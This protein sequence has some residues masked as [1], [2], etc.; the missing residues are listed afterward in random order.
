MRKNTNTNG[1]VLVL[2][3]WLLLL[4]SVF[5]VNIGLRIRQRVELVSR[6]EERNKI[7]HITAA[8]IKKGLAAIKHCFSL[9]ETEYSTYIKSYLR[10][11]EE[12]FKE[13]KV[14]EGIFTVSYQQYDDL[15][16][17]YRSYYGLVDEESKININ[18]ADRGTLQRL[19]LRSV[20][21]DED[22]ALFYADAIIDWRSLGKS[23]IDGFLSDDYYTNLKYPYAKKSSPYELMDELLLVEGMNQHVLSGVVDHM[24]VYGDGAVN[25][26]T[27]SRV[28][29]NALGLSEEL[30]DKILSVRRGSDGLEATADDFIFL[31][32]FDIAS[33]MSV[34]VKVT[35]DEARTIDA[36][37]SRGLIKT[38]SSFYLIE[39]VGK[40]KKRRRSRASCVFDVAANRIIYYKEK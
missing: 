34:F 10:N 24:T 29:L 39:S 22:E 6:I 13:I 26:N 3:L 11:N 12:K 33:D 38:N 15:R 23:R 28:V 4:L 36:L 5:L 27:A 14:G 16:R 7:H 21:T 20:A 32:P 37:N 9:G 8:G 1:S 19:F 18:V 31:K 17:D 25:I 2:S 30:I 35:E 40:L